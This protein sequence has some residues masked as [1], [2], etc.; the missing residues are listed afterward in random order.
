MLLAI[1]CVGSHEEMSA[2]QLLLAEWCEAGLLTSTEARA[3]SQVAPVCRWDEEWFDPTN[4]S[5][6][7]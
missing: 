7:G 5:A 2:G 1:R 6:E 3:L 4:G